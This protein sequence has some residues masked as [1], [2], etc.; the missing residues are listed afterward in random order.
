MSK[1]LAVANSFQINPHS[2]AEGATQS[3]MQTWD[4]CPEKWYLQY[5]LMLARR[6]D[7]S[8]ALVYGTWI[9]SALEEFYKSRGKRWHLDCT[10]PADVRSLLPAKTLEQ[11]E[12]Y[13]KLA[14]VQMACYAS[15]YKGDKSFWKVIATEEIVDLTFEGIRLKGMIDLVVESETYG[16]Y[17]IVDH[18]TT[19]SLD[20]SVLEGWDFRLQFMFYVWLARKKWPDKKI[21]GYY[22]N[23]MK[24]PQ[25][26]RKQTE[27]MDTFLQRV[28]NDMLT[29]PE[30]YF[31]RQRLKLMKGSMK[32]FEKEILAPKLNRI[33]MM[34][35]NSIPDSV[36]IS[37]VRNKN[38]D[39]CLH[40][41]RPCQF[42]AACK[43]GLDVESHA[44]HVREHKHTELTDTPE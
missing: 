16:G 44:F 42:L 24:K 23:A 41:G 36:K 12:Y 34:R 25:L 35:D 19:S 20:P 31:Y 40:Y 26:K 11:E 14:D 21:R 13:V 2:L 18:K 10:I 15:M 29:R 33:R 28:Q 27:S 32:H 7:F 3:E 30:A 22:I 39:H 43:N 37:L 8:W 38:T 4:N 6:G 9:H 1:S 5:N 17:Y